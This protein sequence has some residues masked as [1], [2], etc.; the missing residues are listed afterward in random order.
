M[1]NKL[2]IMMVL[3]Q[4]GLSSHSESPQLLNRHLTIVVMA[5]T[6]PL[7]QKHITSL[8]IA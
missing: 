5:G 6:V 8:N 4:L 1:T 7:L 3:A 2:L